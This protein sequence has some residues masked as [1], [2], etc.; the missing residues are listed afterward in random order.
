MADE[1]IKRTLAKAEFTGN[2]RDEYPTALIHALIDSVP[3]ADVAP[4]RRGK[5]VHTFGGYVNCSE[6]NATPLLDG[7]REY[8]ETPYCPNCGAKMDG[9]ET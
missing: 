9:G 3:A 7:E 1:Y 6:C 8:V 2:F 4:V 5:W